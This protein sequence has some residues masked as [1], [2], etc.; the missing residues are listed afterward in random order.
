MEL[1]LSGKTALVTG[2]SKGIGKAVAIEL[3]AEGCNLHLAS[4]T[5]ADLEAARDELLGR[6]NVSVDIHAADLS[7]AEGR[8]AVIDGA[9]DIDILI[10]NAGAI[11]GGDI[12]DVQD[13]IWREAW[14]LKVF[15]YINLSRHYYGAMKKSGAGVII[16]VCGIAG[17]TPI[18]RYIAGST[19]NAALGMFSRALG[20]ESILH[21]VR[22][23]AVHPGPTLTER[24]ITLAR[25]WAEK[26]LGDPERWQELPSDHR[27]GRAAEPKE[28][29]D[30]VVFMASERASYMSG[31]AVDVG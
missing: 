26:E 7:T 1:N 25:T 6:Y 29:A 13:D 4:R 23:L 3:A 19:G 2:G 16:N 18:P 27:L 12:D 14:D 5:A 8:Q 11:P 17:V 10:N 22:V 28:V 9:G 20:Q 15:G 24:L 30:V 21:G 31:V